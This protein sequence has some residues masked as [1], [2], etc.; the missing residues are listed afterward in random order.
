MTIEILE[1][2][3]GSPEYGLEV[4]LRNK[5]LRQPLGL[6]FSSDELAKECF[7]IHLG[8]FLGPAM[9]GCLLLRRVNAHTAKMRQVAIDVSAQGRGIGRRLV[10]TAEERARAMGYTVI[11]LNARA[12]AIAFYSKLGYEVCGEPF[13]E[14]TLA[15]QKMRKIL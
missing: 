11:E 7:D 3:H 8:A 15:H 13:T 2:Q 1:I 4:T 14:L 12:T 6:H 9:V 5:I 10:A